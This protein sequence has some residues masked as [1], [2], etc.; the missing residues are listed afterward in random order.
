MGLF[1]LFK[2]LNSPSP[3]K[4]IKAAR[5]GNLKLVNSLLENGIDVNSRDEK[6]WTPLIWASFNGNAELIKKL[7]EKG[8]D[9]NFKNTEGYTALISASDRGWIE[10][11]KMLLDAGAQIDDKNKDEIQTLLNEPVFPLPEAQPPFPEFAKKHDLSLVVEVEKDKTKLLISA[12]KCT[13][14]WGDNSGK[15]EYNSIKKKEISHSYYKAGSYIISIDASELSEFDCTNAEV[16]SIYL[17]NCPKLEILWCSFNKLTSLDISR[18]VALKILWCGYNNLTSL[19]LSSNLALHALY[20]PKNLLTCLDISK[21]TQL[22]EVDSSHNQLTLL[23]VRNS[24]SAIA[25]LEFNNN[26]LSKNELNRIFNQ[27][28]N[29]NSSYGTVHSWYAGATSTPTIFITCGYNSGFNSCNEK[30]AQNKNWLVWIKAMYIS[31]TLA[32]TP[33]RWQEDY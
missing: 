32:G 26:Q 23:N 7:I 21:N 14:D 17:N 6:G 22:K 24:N 28:P 19:D 16:A 11:V 12:N 8:A 20:C 25:R 31:A 4:L 3:E 29:Y 15:N 5:K 27:L 1:D 18:C 33:A 10:T 13:I 2:K 30:I 9:I